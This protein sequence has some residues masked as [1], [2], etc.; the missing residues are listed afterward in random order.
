MVSML[1]AHPQVAVNLRDR[2][3]LT[4]LLHACK[5]GDTV[6]CLLLGNARVNTSVHDR[7]NRTALWWSA[8]NCNTETV[9]SLLANGKALNVHRARRLTFALQ[10]YDPKE[11]DVEKAYTALEIARVCGYDGIVGHLE[12]LMDNPAQTKSADGSFGVVRRS[13]S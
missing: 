11:G 3:R 4:P 5:T 2:D 6:A 13:C 9:E 8:W 1:L 12:G 10:E 7:Y